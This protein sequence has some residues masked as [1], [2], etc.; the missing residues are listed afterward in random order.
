MR[1]VVTGAAGFIG[2]HLCEALLARGCNVV[3]ID[4]FITGSS[5]NLKSFWTSDRFT[6]GSQTREN[7]FWSLASGLPLWT[8]WEAVTLWLFS[9]GH[10]PWVDLADHPVYFVVLM[11]LVPI[12]T[13]IHF[14]AVHRLIHW[15]PLYKAVHSLHHRNTNPAPWS[16]LSIGSI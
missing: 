9:S 5:D 10:I 12:W 13:E 8:A 2:S 4:N 3:G 16:G 7:V 14:Y 1:V 15:P 11:L 6:F